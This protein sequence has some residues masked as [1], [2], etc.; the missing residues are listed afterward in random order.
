MLLVKMACERARRVSL[1]DGG[2]C[3]RVGLG[4][5]PGG[6]AAQWL[7]ATTCLFL[8]LFAAG[9]GQVQAQRSNGAG[10][11][12]AAVAPNIPA[13]D[14]HLSALL[15]APVSRMEYALGPGDVVDLSVFGELNNLYRLTVTPE[16]A[17]VIPAVGVVNVL[18]L[19]LEDAQ[20]RVREQVL[21]L[22][23]NIGIHLTLSR[24]RHFKVY[25]VGDV[26]SPG[27]QVASAATRVSEIVRWDT[28]RT[29]I[30]RNIILRR[31]SGEVATVDLVRFR[32]TGDLSANPLLREGDALVIPAVD[33]TIQI[34]GRAAFPG[35]YDYR[36]GETLAELLAIANGGN[37]LPTDAA[38]TLRLSR[39]VDRN[40]Q[41]I[42]TFSHAEAFG[43]AGQAFVLRPFDALYIP[44]VVDYQQQHTATISGQVA[45]PGTYPIRPD[46]TTVRDLVALAGGFVPDASLT[47]S[48]LQRRPPATGER[49]L[50]QLQ[51]VPPELLSSQERRVLQAGARG[52]DTHVVIDFQ[53]L[54]AQGEDAY[55][56]VLR[57]GDSLSVPRRSDEV[58]ILGAVLQPGMV[59]Y[60][61][62]QGVEH[63]VRLAGG[64]GR[65]ADR[66][67]VVVVR[68]SSGNRLDASDARRI[69][70]G[71]A[72]IVPFRERRDYLRTLQTTSTVVTTV[73]GMILTFLALT[74]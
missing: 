6:W 60:T 22:Y 55:N 74:R 17:V 8:L 4:R 53:R 49:R 73:T 20:S 42:H 54:F 47:G 34:H 59:Q 31:G 12:A 9:A 35:T 24:I 15:D 19:N 65:N 28:A 72:I 58:V 30:P 57:D 46:T 37:R 27:V 2:T 39:M 18:G 13:T 52:D 36:P 33:Q 40:R 26:G 45:F 69:E 51:G 7:R 25:V 61:P 48:S 71:D 50:R 11:D 64:Y 10:I 63:F 1:A 66:R 70:P 16:G 3:G 68:A 62:E 43:P 14:A 23:R 56:Q 5:A 41:E 21:R 67:D 32:H 29:V 44:R 38:D